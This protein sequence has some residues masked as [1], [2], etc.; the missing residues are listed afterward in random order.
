MATRARKLLSVSKS[1]KKS[2]PSGKHKHP[3]C[4]VPATHE[5][6]RAWAIAARGKPFAVHA[7]GLLDADAEA[8]GIEITEKI[9]DQNEEEE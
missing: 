8:Q 1:S 6:R 9:G 2:R 4:R 5:Q 3:V 7:R